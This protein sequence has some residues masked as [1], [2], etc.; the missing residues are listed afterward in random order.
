MLRPPL[1]ARVAVAVALGLTAGLMPFGAF[2]AVADDGPSTQAASKPAVVLQVPF[3]CD[4]TWRGDSRSKPGVH[5]GPEIDFNRGATPEADKGSPVLAAAPGEV[6]LAGF[7]K[8]PDG[9]GNVVKIR[10]ADDTYT[11]YA[12]LDSI[13][14]AVKVGVEV[15][16]AQR[17]GK[18]GGTSDEDPNMSPHLHFEHRAGSGQDTVKRVSFDGKPF[19]YPAQEVTSR[20]DCDPDEPGRPVVHTAADDL[21]GR[22]QPRKEPRDAPDVYA[23]GKKVSVVCK[24]SGGEAYGSRT[25]ALTTRHLYVPAAILRHEG[26]VGVAPGTPDCRSPLPVRAVT[27]LNGRQDKDRASK[28]KVD[29]YGRGAQVPVVCT[30]YGAGTYHGRHTWARTADKVWV[31]R[32]YLDLPGHGL[33][34]GLPRCDMDPP[35]KQKEEQDKD[36]EKG[37]RKAVSGLGASAELAQFIADEEGFEPKPYND[38]DRGGNCT[39][40]YGNKLHDGPCTDEDYRLPA[41]TEKQAMDELKTRLRKTFVPATRA[42]LKGLQMRQHEFDALVSMVYNLG[43]EEIEGSDLHDAL[44][45]DPSG[46]DDVPKLMQRFVR[47]DGE[48]L[49]GLHKRRVEEGRVFS[50]AD[51]KTQATDKVCRDR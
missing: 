14:P 50:N 1:V 35:K 7:Q 46:W 41:V 11:L 43:A 33:I 26:K 18:L 49:C 6:T 40:G 23:R 22:V 31:V 51:Y 28:S 16:Q 34:A 29:M 48:Y 2:P 19:A 3:P 45:G 20:N 24:T 38:N 37:V 42:L 25:W 30:A 8:S 47:D 5:R 21:D 17:V 12:H 15:R 9:L 27:A 10:H 13:D 4:Q 39:Q 36:N 32:E 44:R